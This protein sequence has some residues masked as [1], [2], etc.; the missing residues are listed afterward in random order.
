MRVPVEGR[1]GCDV[2]GRLCELDVGLEVE[3]VA[4]EL[5]RM[6]AAQQQSQCLVNRWQ[7]LDG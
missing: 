4:A 6:F 2:A 5:R 7:G 3:V 1:H